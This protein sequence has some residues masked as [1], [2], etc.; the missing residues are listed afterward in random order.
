MTNPYELWNT[1]RS[2][3]VFRDVEPTYKYW[4][5][6][7]QNEF[8]STDEYIDFEKLPRVGRKLAAFAM[9]LARGK[10]V[11]DDSAKLYRFK[12][13]YVKVEDEIDPLM[14]LTKRAGI[15]R[16]IIEPEA[17][18]PMQR[19][20]LIRTAMTIWA[21]QAIE[22]R[23]DWMAAK[24]IIDGQVTL[25]GENYPTTLVDFGRAAGHT[26]VLGSGQR[27]GDS[28]VSIV[29]HFQSVMDTVND[30]EFGGMVVRVTMGSAVW[31]IA[32]KD[33]EFRDHMDTQISG[34]TI[35]IDRGLVS[36]DKV[37]KVGEMQ[38]G[39]ASGA[40]VELWVNN[41]TF[42][43]PDTGAETRFVGTKEVVFTC[44]PAAINGFQCFGRIIDRAAN[45][46]ALP[47]FPSNWIQPGDPAV[48]YLTHKSAPLFVPINANATFKSTVLA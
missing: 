33:T 32:R 35:K 23:W 40:T 37:F 11:Y 2:L 25:S 1:R 3:G 26:Q 38:V 5:P 15:D 18:T 45:Y 8:R 16:S 19:L 14:P 34:G 4:T 41:D 46:E 43:D 24:A 13:G 28:G 47:I 39:G 12:P 29:D 6:M 36:S 17:I 20:S 31:A 42:I 10:S 48:E 9:P 30:A 21:V 27:Y 44:S 22:R 7:F